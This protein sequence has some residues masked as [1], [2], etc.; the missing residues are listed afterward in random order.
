MFGKKGLKIN[1]KDWHRWTSFCPCY[2]CFWYGRILKILAYPIVIDNKLAW[3]IPNDLYVM[4]FRS[5]IPNAE[6][7]IG[8]SFFTT[9]R[10]AGKC[11]II[12]TW[13]F[14]LG[15]SIAK[16]SFKWSLIFYLKVYPL[17]V[18]TIWSKLVCKDRV[19][20]CIVWYW[21]LVLTLWCLL[22]WTRV[23]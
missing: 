22:H 6:T 2:T 7:F 20:N 13:L 1:R 11:T 16:S 15:N 19:K 23:A 4:N 8:I 17:R 5:K 14:F 9:L 3:E 12:Y 10:K 21:Y 18:F